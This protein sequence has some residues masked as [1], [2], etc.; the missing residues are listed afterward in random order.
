V[1]L[2]GKWGLIDK[3]GKIIVNPQFKDV[4]SMWEGQIRVRLGNKWGLI[5]K[6]GQYLAEPQFDLMLPHRNYD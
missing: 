5:D 2:G 4:R 3:T 1:R 6:T